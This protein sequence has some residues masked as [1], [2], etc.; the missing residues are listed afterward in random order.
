MASRLREMVRYGLVGLVNAATYLLLYTALLLLG[1][2]YVAAAVLGFPP[3]VAL[4]YW[5]HEHWTFERGQPSRRGLATFAATQVVALVLSVLMLVAV[6]D[7]LGAD[8]I[9]GRVVTTPVAPVFT[10]VVG[11]AWVFSKVPAHGTR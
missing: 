5:L 10:Y 3:S 9:L 11:R 2:P 1:V 8:E 6:V 7:G 4:G